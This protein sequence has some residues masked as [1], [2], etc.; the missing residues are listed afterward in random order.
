M[1]SIL[2]TSLISYLVSIACTGQKVD[3]FFGAV[4]TSCRLVCF[5]NG[6]PKGRLQSERNVGPFFRDVKQH[7]STEGVIVTDGGS[8]HAAAVGHR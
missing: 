5:K 6:H 3:F 8:D 2:L 1:T 7:R 4:L